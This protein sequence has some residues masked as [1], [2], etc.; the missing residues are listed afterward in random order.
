MKEHFIYRD[1]THAGKVLAEI[2]QEHGINQPVILA[3][4]RGG[5]PVAKE[6]ADRLGLP[7]DVLIVRKIGAPFN[8]EYGIGAL[9]EDLRPLLKAG[10][11]LHLEHLQNEVNTIIEKEKKELQR[12][13]KHYREQRDIPDVKDKT[14]LLVDDGLA[15]G[16]TAA[17]AGRFLHFKGAK[18]VILCVP[19]GPKD[20]SELLRANIDEIIC[21]YKPDNFFSIGSWFSDF[22]QVSDKEVTSILKRYHPEQHIDLSL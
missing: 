20:M 8:T 21:L 3:L 17:A 11:M 19:V 4:P 2:I 7:L 5:V 13:I 15:T 6:I 1:R 18:D 10:D 14:V 16:V 9:C 22:T 12:R